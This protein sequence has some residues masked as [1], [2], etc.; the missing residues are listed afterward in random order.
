L[1]KRIESFKEYLELA[2]KHDFIDIGR[3]KY[4]GSNFLRGFEGAAGARQE[5]AKLKS[6]EEIRE[7][8]GNI[9]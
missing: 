3:I 2:E 6:L 9:K 4:L 5:F 1:E 7:F 8:I